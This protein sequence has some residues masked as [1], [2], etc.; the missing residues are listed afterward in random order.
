MKLAPLSE[1]KD[2]LSRLVEYVRRGGRVRIVVRGQPA[3]DLVPIGRQTASDL[4]DDAVLASL[5]RQGVVKRGTGRLPRDLLRSGPKP[6]GV[7]ASQTLLAER[8]SGW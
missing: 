5:E 7:P 6:R 8:R 2:N 1:A 3:A 4:G